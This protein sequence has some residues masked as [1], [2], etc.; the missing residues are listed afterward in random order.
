MRAYLYRNYFF[1]AVIVSSV[2][3]GML[4]VGG[5]PFGYSLFINAYIW[6]ALVSVYLVFIYFRHRNI[7]VMFLNLQIRGIGHLFLAAFTFVVFTI[8]VTIIFGGILGL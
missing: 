5:F 7:W 1:I 3:F 6:G 4:Y 8:I 2:L